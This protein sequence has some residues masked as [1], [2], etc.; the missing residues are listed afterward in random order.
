M[1]VNCDLESSILGILRNAYPIPYTPHSVCLTLIGHKLVEMDTS[2][3]AGLLEECETLSAIV[4]KRLILLT[5][6]G[7]AKHYPSS[8][9]FAAIP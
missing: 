4:R 3:Y 8:D 1:F 2:D 7:L 5:E 9:A 6:S